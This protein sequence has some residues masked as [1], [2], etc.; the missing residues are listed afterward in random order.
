MGPSLTNR[1]GSAYRFWLAAR[2]ATHVR[3]AWVTTVRM[4]RPLIFWAPVAAELG[5]SESR[6]CCGARMQVRWN[7][8][9][10]DL[11]ALSEWYQGT[12]GPL[13]SG[14]ALLTTSFVSSYGAKGGASWILAGAA[15]TPRGGFAAVWRPN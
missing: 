2:S 7:E 8:R 9:M 11:S 4:T 10:V 1:G 15:F 13:G 3:V 6:A 12:T 14:V 5:P